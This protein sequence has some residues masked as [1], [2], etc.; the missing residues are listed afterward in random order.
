MEKA[1]IR[2]VAAMA[3]VSVAT[4]SRILNGQGGYGIETRKRV[5]EAMGKLDYTPNALA[6]G[7][8]SSS[9]RTIGVLMPEV[10]SSFASLLLHGIE[11]EAQA[12]DYSTIVCNTESNGHRSLEYL[13]VLSEKRVDGLVFVSENL[14]EEYGSALESLGV[15]IV[16]AATSSIRFPFPY[17]KV[18]DKLASYHAVKYLI[19]CGH[20]DIGL[21]SGSPCDAIAGGPRIEGWRE[22][23]KDHVL[24]AD[25]S[26][27]AYGD[28]HFRSGREAAALLMESRPG[29]SAIFA[30][31]DEMALGVLSFAYSRG[32]KV[33]DELSVMGYDDSLAAEMAIPPL[34]TVHQPIVDIGREAA[35]MLFEKAPKTASSILPFSIVERKSVLKRSSGV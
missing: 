28:F 19:G 33:P 29:L 20:R 6:R 24:P 23:M 11:S 26:A 16:L 1:T 17:V 14:T 5:E 35:R 9:L 13:R 32:I 18:D 30:T 8:M 22:C 31:S 3:G 12:R 7:L 25:E 21:I 10:T 15:P 34:T 27:V 4:V 2:D